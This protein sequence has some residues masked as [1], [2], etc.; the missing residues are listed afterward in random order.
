MMHEPAPRRSPAARGIAICAIALCALQSVGPL[1]D[2]AN[3]ASCG[4]QLRPRDTVWLV[5]SR[6][7]GS[8]NLDENLARLKCWRFDHEHAWT[9]SQ[10]AELVDDLQPQVVTV[11]FLH[12]NRVSSCEAFTK[13]WQAY[14]RLA[15]C[16]DDQPVRFVIWSWPSSKVCGPVQDVRIKAARTSSH[17]YYLAWFLDQLDDEAPVSLW[18]F[19]YG[20][21][22]ATGA[23]HLLGGGTL[24][25]HRLET[26][27]HPDRQPMR[28]ALMAAALD[29]HWLLPGHRHGN[30]WSQVHSTLLVNNG[31]DRVL[32]RYHFLYGRG[33]CQE[34]LGYVGLPVWRLPDDDAKKVSQLDACC[35]VGNQHAFDNYL[36]SS[37]VMARLRGALLGDQPPTSE[38]ARDDVAGEARGLEPVTP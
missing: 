7:L 38:P 6:G 13:G 12:G 30:A 25:G 2:R 8:C 11:V 14:R 20:A 16:A 19:S 36:A 37:R 18:G 29:D 10:L 26:R 27:L 24:D 15:Q 5:S 28:L 21:R 17:G 3:A 31:C 32:A 22:I 9:P 23:L 4:G 34:A 35:Y 33:G 1:S